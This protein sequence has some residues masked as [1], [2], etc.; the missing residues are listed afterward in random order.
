MCTCIMPGC[1]SVNDD[2]LDF[3]SFPKDSLLY[4]KWIKTCNL[5][6]FV[7]DKN[8]G[9]YSKYIYFTIIYL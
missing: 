6:M 1:T 5:D 3:F 4:Q 8:E 7:V 9:G 2:S